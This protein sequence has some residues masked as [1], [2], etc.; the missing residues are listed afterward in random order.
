MPKCVSETSP[1]QPI[2][3]FPSLGLRTDNTSEVVAAWTCVSRSETGDLHLLSRYF[4]LLQD[5]ISLNSDYNVKTS[6]GSKHKFW[7]KRTATKVNGQQKRE[8]SQGIARSTH[9]SSPAAPSQWR[10]SMPRRTQPPKTLWRPRA[11]RGRGKRWGSV[12]LL[13]ILKKR[14]V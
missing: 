14:K 7:R 5:H 6:H 8:K 1:S 10:P 11:L 2:K 13:K 9:P 12:I 4:G 3:A